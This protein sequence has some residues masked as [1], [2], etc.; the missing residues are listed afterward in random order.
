[1]PVFRVPDMTCSGCVQA[2]LNAVRLADP[3]SIVHVELEPKLVHVDSA[4]PAEA[5]AEVLR[6]A[7]FTPEPAG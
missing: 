7:G 6:D 4:Q 1:M 2:I 5:F 3:A